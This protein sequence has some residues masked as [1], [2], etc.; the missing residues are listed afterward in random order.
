MEGREKKKKKKKLQTDA[1]L[2]CLSG[3]EQLPFSGACVFL[4]MCVH[5]GMW[6]C[7]VASLCLPTGSGV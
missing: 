7:A 1:R 5:A 2:L 3:D 6:G 4:H